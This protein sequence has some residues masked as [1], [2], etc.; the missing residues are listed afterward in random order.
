MRAH[1]AV[2]GGG[3][4]GCAI[5]REL[6]RD[7][8][9]VTVFERRTP[10]AEASSA[11]LGLLFAH[12][13]SDAFDPELLA[14]EKASLE[15]YPDFV[16]DLEEETG[17]SVGLRRN[18]MIEAA[19]TEEHLAALRARSVDELRFGVDMVVVDSDEVRRHEP[20]LAPDTLGG[21]LYSH[22]Y[23][24]HTPRLSSSVA[25]AASHA[26]AQ[27]RLGETVVDVR[28]AQPG[29]PAQVRLQRGERLDFDAVVVAAGAWASSLLPAHVEPV[30]PIRGQALTLRPALPRLRHSVT[31]GKVTCV[32]RGHL[33][34]MGG[35]VE[36]VGFEPR[37]TAGGIAGMLSAALPTIPELADASIVAMW[38]GLR[39][40]TPSG[41]PRIGWADD[42]VIGAVGHY[43]SGVI[44]APLTARWVS[45]L[46]RGVEL[47]D[48]ASLVAPGMVASGLAAPG[49]VAPGLVARGP[50][51]E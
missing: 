36:D 12:V 5:A 28:A 1:I 32:P 2:I 21:A 48:S 30:R 13:H 14:L 45:M 18:G 39:P 40:A 16:S 11:A 47:P 25:A 8:L 20:S 9:A 41:R 22:S 29:Q 24:V 23:A 38:A 33:V 37:P 26:G 35:T 3:I 7:G 50:I 34:V 15:L 51:G 10:A 46:V 43:R 27:F 6:A 4:I 49:L 17:I 44:L 42:G 31:N 19:R